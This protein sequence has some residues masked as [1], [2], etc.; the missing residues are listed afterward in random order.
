VLLQIITKSR[1]ITVTP[2]HRFFVSEKERIIEKC[3][4]K[5]KTEDHIACTQQNI[6]EPLFTDPSFN[7]TAIKNKC[8]A[9]PLSEMS[10]HPKDRFVANNRQV[11]DLKSFKEKSVESYQ[12][13]SGSLRRRSHHDVKWEKIIE[14]AEIPSSHGYV[15]DLTV[16]NYENYVANGIIVHNSAWPWRIGREA[17]VFEVKR[18]TYDEILNS[19]LNKDPN[20]FKFTVETNPA[21]GKYHW[22][23]H[24]N[25]RVSL[26]PKEATK[27]GNVC[28]VCRRKLTKG[29]EQRVEELADRPSGFEPK[30]AIGYLHLLPLSEIIAKVLKVSY[31]G[32]QKVWRVYNALVAR[33]GD[34]YAVLMDAARD[35]MALTVDPK[36]A[37]AISRVRT[38][39][40][41]IMPGYDGV[42]GELSLH[43]GGRPKIVKQRSIEDFIPDKT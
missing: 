37:D 39:R 11:I 35:E 10:E 7:E 33:F 25:C 24:R 3:A 8:P 30:K 43:N 2:L 17:N 21:Y 26:P 32:S 1:S 29:V 20:C 42:Y 22:T 12:Y 28:P 38:G 5:L 41:R 19:I 36:I 6:C 9:K 14:I 13:L 27:L 4:S 18:L 34:E 31:S 16:P 40:V 23:G 15:Y